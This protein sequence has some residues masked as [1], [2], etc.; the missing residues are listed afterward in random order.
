MSFQISQR[1]KN[2]PFQNLKLKKCSK[3]S[4]HF[5][6][7]HFVAGSLRFFS[8]HFVKLFKQILLEFCYT[9]FWP[10][11]FDFEFFSTDFFSVCFL[12]NSMLESC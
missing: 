12:V 3:T 9:D 1:N 4:Y 8:V 7:V 2:L 6:S 11:D 10:I 5:F